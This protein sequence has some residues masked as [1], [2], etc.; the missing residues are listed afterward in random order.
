[1]FQ[2]IMYAHHTRMYQ[3]SDS[4]HICVPFNQDWLLCRDFNGLVRYA[5]LTQ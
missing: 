5:A 4:P 3:S 1:M 2:T